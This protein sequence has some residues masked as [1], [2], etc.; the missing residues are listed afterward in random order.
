MERFGSPIG[1]CVERP[2]SLLIPVAKQPRRHVQK[3]QDGS[4]YEL[5]SA[6]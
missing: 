6:Q 2:E 3:R 5:Q 1:Y 4:K